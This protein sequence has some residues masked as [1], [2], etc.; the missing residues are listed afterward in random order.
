[1]KVLAI[2]GSHPRSLNSRTLARGWYHSCPT[3]YG[4][5]DPSG[6]CPGATGTFEHPFMDKVVNTAINKTANNRKVFK[7]FIVI[8]KMILTQ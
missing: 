8:I 5:G 1:M 4:F 6:I 7:I 3:R 2:P